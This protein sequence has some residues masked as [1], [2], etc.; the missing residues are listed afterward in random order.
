MAH[1][2]P[3]QAFHQAGLALAGRSASLS[4]EDIGH[5]VD[6]YLA[7][8]EEEYECAD[9]ASSF[10]RAAGFNATAHQTFLEIL[11]P[12]GATVVGCLQQRLA[13]PDKKTVALAAML[14]GRFSDETSLPDLTGAKLRLGHDWKTV[15]FIDNAIQQIAK[16]T[17]P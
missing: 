6:A 13:S 12:H 14:L 4:G 2:F 10:A 1:S 16:K 15:G 7:V 5:V 17:K 8:I 11:Q 3:G 9:D